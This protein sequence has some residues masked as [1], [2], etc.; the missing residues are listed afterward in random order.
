MREYSWFFPT[1]SRHHRKHEPCDCH[2]PTIPPPVDP[3]LYDTAVSQV[4]ELSDQLQEIRRRLLE[5]LNPQR[6]R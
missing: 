6:S 1:C 4:Q 2:H 5:A 3:R